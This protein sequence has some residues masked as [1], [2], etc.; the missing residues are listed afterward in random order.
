MKVTV[1][2]YARLHN[3]GNYENER[4]ELEATVES[5][6][7]REVYDSLARMAERL[8]GLAVE[9]ESVESGSS[10]DLPF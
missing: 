7:V 6:S 10:D 2:R 5:E 8:L 1:V 4:V 9:P 3:L